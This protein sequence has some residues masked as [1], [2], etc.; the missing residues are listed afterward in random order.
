MS[1]KAVLL[2][3]AALP[4]CAQTPDAAVLEAQ[5]A[6]LRSLIAHAPRLSVERIA[7][8]IQPPGAAWE[9]GYPSSVAMDKNGEI[10]VLQRGEKADPVLVLN[11]DGRVLR[12]WGKGMFKIPHSIRIDSAGNIWTVDASSSLVY[13]FTPKG[14]K[15]MEISVGG[16]PPAKSGFNGTTDIAFAPNGHL[17]ISDGYGNARV[18]EYTP[19][20]K[21][22]R[23]WGSAGTGPGQF[24]QPHG[25]AIDPEEIVYV[26][27]R[28]NGRLQRFDLQGRFLGEWENLGMVT[29]VATGSGGLWIGTQQRNEPTGADGWIMKIDPKTGAIL[30]Y[31]ESAHGQH[32]VNVAANGDLLSG[33]RPDTVVWFHAVKR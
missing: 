3:L 22:V 7:F 8:K 25:I 17:F 24:H 16:Q 19:D 6:K 4:A 2:C 1:I 12:S 32:V 29:S 13:K 11:R 27:D 31:V 9:I 30:G 20:G 5:A 21:R 15:L 18:L 33:A 23:E 14:A 28:Q 10:Y 26:A